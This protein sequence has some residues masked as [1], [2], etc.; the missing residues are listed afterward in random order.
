LKRNFNE[1]SIKINEYQSLHQKNQFVLQKYHELKAKFDDQIALNEKLQKF[2]PSFNK[3]QE[4]LPTYSIEKLI[5]KF[6]Y[7]ETMNMDFAKKICEFE[8]DKTKI[9]SDLKKKKAK[10][11]EELDEMSQKNRESQRFL[12]NLR[13]QMKTQENDF[14]NQD[15]YKNNYF[16]LFKKIL[17]I[18]NLY[19]SKIPVYF[20]QKDND[21]P[22]ANMEDPMELLELLEK[23][24]GISNDQ[25]L[26][27]YLRKII[28]NAN[29]LQRKFFPEKVNERFN[30]EKIYERISNYIEQLKGDL[31]RQ[32][33]E[34]NNL[35]VSLEKEKSKMNMKCEEKAKTNKRAKSAKVVEEINQE[36]SRRN[37]FI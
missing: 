1:K 25:R 4:K 27:G 17:Y 23:L 32:K 35:R 8:D 31:L 12:E 5:D 30:P 33:T 21:Q 10:F 6:E 18:F 28:I 37:A 29:S 19:S 20:N 15:N 7:L 3:L 24:I 34:I 16:A 9:E 11:D 22:K 26:I 14:Q 13:N 2:E 36:K